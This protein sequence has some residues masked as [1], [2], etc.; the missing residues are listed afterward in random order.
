MWS[1]KK[2][3]IDLKPLVFS[4]GKSQEDIV[5]DILRELK[6]HKFIFLKGV[7]GTGK[8]AI[9]LNVANHFKKSSIVVPVKC[10]QEQYKTDYQN[11]LS[12]YRKDGTKLKISI[13]DGRAN[14]PCIYNKESKC[15]D[16]TL[17][18]II[19]IKKYNYEQIMGY[20]D[21]NPNVDRKDFSDLKFVR[22]KSIAPACQY[23]SPI[24]ADGWFE[25][26]YIDSGKKIKYEGLNNNIF[27]IY[28]N[29][30]C[31]YYDQFLSYVNS[32]VIIFNSA[33]YQIETAMNRKPLTDIEIID[34]GDKFLD[35]LS[36]E[37]FV[38][39]DLF[40]N[41]LNEV[42]QNKDAKESANYIIDYILSM[43]KNNK[44][45]EWVLK[46][47]ILSLEETPLK[48]LFNLLLANKELSEF[49]ELEYYYFLADEFKN[50]KKESYVLF[51]TK[52]NKL[53]ANIVVLDLA[54]KLKHMSEKNKV[55]L[56]MSGT[57]PSKTILTKLFGLKDEFKII[58]AEAKNQGIIH[59]MGTG[60]E[61]NFRYS[62]FKK[63]NLTRGDYLKAF[64]ACIKKAPKPCLIHIISYNDLPSAQEKEEFQL[65]M[66]TS[67][68][69]IDEK[70]KDMISKFKNREI[71][72]LYSTVCDRGVD[73]P[74]S[75]CN[76]IVFSKYPYPNIND[77][78]F[79][80]VLKKTNEELFWHFYNDKAYREY[81]QRIYRGL[82]S[83]DD[84]IFLLSPDIKVLNSSI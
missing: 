61:R 50:F 81:L 79:L 75:I 41:R 74:G 23:W 39:F 4:N 26:D 33:K 57:L 25:E 36:D 82:R 45:R 38:N 9:S 15:D 77:S 22:R 69:I 20:I 35:N 68:E 2:G 31:H 37:S 62:E 34:E 83:K 80:R 14:H 29:R 53:C 47:E 3:D 71:D 6:D 78:L 46:D 7:C 27:T 63:G 10:L 84:I 32:D 76:S 73:F 19:P 13:I 66:K 58:E 1:L 17:P 70:N 43:I 64:D 40:L 18:C 8:S 72:T 52:D 28:W 60:L 54:K 49:E 59:K 65:N 55:F 48:Q 12:I 56:F 44:I 11:K 30:G 24:V 21:E 5:N 67:N 16:K 51:S 42:S